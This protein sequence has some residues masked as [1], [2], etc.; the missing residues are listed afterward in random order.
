MNT[1]DPKRLSELTWSTNLSPKSGSPNEYIVLMC[2]Y[3]AQAKARLF[4]TD[5]L[6]SVVAPTCPLT[7]AIEP[8]KEYPF[9]AEPSRLS[10]H[11]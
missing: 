5:L 3:F 9:S 1:G 7:M 8:A 4:E 6:I 11:A 10:V 2:S